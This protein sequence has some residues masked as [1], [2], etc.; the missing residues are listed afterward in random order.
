MDITPANGNVA[1]AQIRKTYMVAQKEERKD[2]VKYG[3]KHLII[4][5]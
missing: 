3:K 5:D 2:K 1:L 4:L